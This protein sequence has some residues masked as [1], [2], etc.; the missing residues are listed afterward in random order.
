M[1]ELEFSPLMKSCQYIEEL[2][3]LVSAE[4]SNDFG[5]GNKVRPRHDVTSY[6][7]LIEQFVKLLHKKER[8]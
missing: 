5:E 8:F 4:C 7:E 3:F 1:L 6:A 2:C